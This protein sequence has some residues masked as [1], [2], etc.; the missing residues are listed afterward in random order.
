MSMSRM[1][2]SMT[3][4]G[5]TTAKVA[6]SV[7]APALLILLAV[8]PRDLNRGRLTLPPTPHLFRHA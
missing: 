5:D 8:A 7:Q 3:T 6:L 1:P 4:N 2:P